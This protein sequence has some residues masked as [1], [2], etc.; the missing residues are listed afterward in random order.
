MH[1]A[2]LVFGVRIDN[3]YGVNEPFGA[4]GN[5]H[6]KVFAFQPAFK[7]F[8]KESFAGGVGL[9]IGYSKG[10]K[11]FLAENSNAIGNQ[12]EYLLGLQAAFNGYGD[13]I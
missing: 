7:Q 3:L 6:F 10:D 2:A 12:D 1:P 9:G 13:T 8:V 4:I 11:F 5:N